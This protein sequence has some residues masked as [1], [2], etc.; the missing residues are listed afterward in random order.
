MVK[1]MQLQE[2]EPGFEPIDRQRAH[3]TKWEMKKR[4][5]DWRSMTTWRGY[6]QLLPSFKSAQIGK[7]PPFLMRIFF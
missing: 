5:G 7:K 4:P 6:P 3:T 2:A 1:V